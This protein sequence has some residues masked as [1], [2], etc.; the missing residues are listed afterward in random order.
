MEVINITTTCLKS[1]LLSQ[2][3]NVFKV[4][5]HTESFQSKKKKKILLI[6]Q[7]FQRHVIYFTVK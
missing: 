5:L 1:L 2:W 7:Y 4:N 6:Y 3:R